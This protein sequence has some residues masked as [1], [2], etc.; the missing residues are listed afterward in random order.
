MVRRM[1]RKDSKRK[2][3][4]ECSSPVLSSSGNPVKVRRRGSRRRMTCPSPGEINKA[5]AGVTL[6]PLTKGC[7]LEELVEKCIQCFDPE[8]NL[9]RSDRVVNMILTMHSWVVPSAK[10]AETVLRL[11]PFKLLSFGSNCNLK[12]CHRAF[13]AI[14]SFV[15]QGIGSSSPVVV[16]SGCLPVPG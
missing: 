1:N 11:Y 3:R 4:Q 15:K 12:I 10:F 8:G 5:I 6:N 14:G 2:S 7:S 13:L 9:C 16:A